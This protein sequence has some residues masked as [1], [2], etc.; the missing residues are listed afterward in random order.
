VIELHRKAPYTRCIGWDVTLDEKETVQLMEWNAWS[1]G[2]MFHEA[3][4]GP[5]FADLGLERLRKERAG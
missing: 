4:Q 1:P 2:I 3:T 5:C